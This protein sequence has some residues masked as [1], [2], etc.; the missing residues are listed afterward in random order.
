MK[1]NEVIKERGR[2][3]SDSGDP[4]HVIYAP[5]VMP[6]GSISLKKSGEENTDDIIESYRMSTDLK[7][8]IQNYLA[9]D[10][11][12]LDRYHGLYLDL[13][14]YPKDYREAMDAFLN[15]E[16]AFTALPDGIRQKFSNDYRQWLA[17]A[18][19]KEWIDSMTEVLYPEKV[20]EN[21]EVKTE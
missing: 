18:G 1:N 2:F 17:L 3:I 7:M 11:S 13:T 14:E 5:V 15:A 8:I 21:D 6:D 4:I 10:Q 12:A 19:T 9:G 20:I 16:M